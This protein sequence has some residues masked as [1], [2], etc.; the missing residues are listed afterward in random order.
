MQSTPRRGR[1]RS[2]RLLAALCAATLLA[3]SACA[4]DPA[5]VGT[6]LTDA[7]A[8]PDV[9]GRVSITGSSTVEP[10]SVRVTE[11]FR[12]QN[13]EVDMSVEGP[14]TGDGFQTFC[15][16]DADIAGASRPIK[17]EE[18]E[19]CDEAGI[20]VIE[21][22]IGLD[23]VVVVT[24]PDNPVECLTFPDLYALLGPEARGISRWRQAEPLAREL[25]SDSDLPDETLVIV[26]PGEESGTFDSFLELALA[27]LTEARVEAGALE[28]GTEVSVRGDYSA[29]AND[30]AIVSSVAAEPGGLG[31]VGFAFA[32]QSD[33]V[34]AVPI[35]AEPGGD[36]VAPSAETVRDGSYP[37]S[38]PLFIYVSAQR[39]AD[40]PAVAAVVDFYLAGLDDFVTAADY[41]TLDA[42]AAAATRERWAER[43]TGPVE[44]G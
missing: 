7:R 41:V 14:G 24:A 2:V 35:A 8:D 43:V 12:A 3:A 31:W 28:P 44:G 10:I 39:A 5:D 34:R 23:G 27:D 37:I 4:L 29:T 25:G 30:N 21:L 6:A 15:A 42:D 38:R 33:G 32:D 18:L 13:D 22:R 19:L 26:G 40:R 20:E 1:L 36:C 11:A 9:S 16:G 17:D